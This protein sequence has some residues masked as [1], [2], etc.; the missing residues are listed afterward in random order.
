[1]ILYHIFIPIFLMSEMLLFSFFCVVD[2]DDLVEVP[3][4]VDEVTYLKSR[5][6]KCKSNDK[7]QRNVYHIMLIAHTYHTQII[8]I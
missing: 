1:M 6:G 3:E 4:D 7:T 8:R 5:L 2:D